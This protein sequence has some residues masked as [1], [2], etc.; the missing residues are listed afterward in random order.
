MEK[1]ENNFLYLVVLGGRAKKANIEL[2]DV[3]WVVGSKIEDTY[4]TLRND[5]F[6]SPKD[7]H[8]DSY[9]KI[10]Y[11]DGYKINLINFEKD[12]IEKKKLLKKNKTKKNLWFINI[13]GYDPNCMQE[14]HEF[15]L[16]VASSKLEAK[17]IAKSKWLIGCKKKHT[18]DIV[19]LEILFSY[20]D[21]QLIKKIGNW[22]IEITL[23]N[24]LIE[25]NNH[26]DWYGY[27]KIDVE[28]Q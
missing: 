13:G 2:H 16:V 22:E 11:V 3:R 10:Q 14:K 23:E 8:I 19:S 4:D 15:G 28:I 27:K 24:N 9:K 17:N 12:N 5:W 1:L 21:C 6:G 20:D 7:L 25:E 26:P 18:D